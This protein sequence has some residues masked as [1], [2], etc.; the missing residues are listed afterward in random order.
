[1]L[2]SSQIFKL[3][4]K[5]RATAALN[6]VI[7][8]QVFGALSE[9]YC[10]VTALQA[11]FA[12]PLYRAKYCSKQIPKSNRKQPSSRESVDH[13]MPKQFI[14]SSHG[15]VIEALSGLCS[16][17]PFLTR[18]DGFPDVVSVQLNATH[19]APHDFLCALPPVFKQ[20]DCFIP[21]HPCR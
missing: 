19:A 3:T 18:L 20:S 21:C 17:T 2:D 15:V 14:N 5:L 7:F 12:T 8:H 4:A 11:S 16:T 9:P 13:R 10:S 1:M 6:V